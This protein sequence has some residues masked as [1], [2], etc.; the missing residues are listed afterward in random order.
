MDELPEV[1]ALVQAGWVPFD[2]SGYQLAVLAAWPA[3]LRGW[4]EDRRPKVVVRVWLDGRREVVPAYGRGD[5]YEEMCETA[6]ECG[7]PAPPR[8]RVWLLRSPWS[9]LGVNVVVRMIWL[10]LEHDDSGP[11][12]VLAVAR[13]ILAMTADEVWQV[14]P[15][16]MRAAAEAWSAAGRS[17]EDVA[18]LV[19]RGLHPVHLERLR[20]AGPVDE[21]LTDAQAAA[22]V[23]AVASSEVD[24][25]AAVERVAQWRELGV[26]APDGDCRP[27]PLSDIAPSEARTWIQAGF[28]VDELE[29]WLG[30]DLADAEK[31]RS[32]GFEARVARD[33]LL[34]DPQLTPVEARAFDAVGVTVEARTRWV[35][36]GFSA[37]EARAWTD[38]DVVPAEARVWRSVGIGP[39]GAD[40]QLAS[41][42]DASP[43]LPSGVAVGWGAMGTGR[44]DVNYGV[45]DPPG[46]RGSAAATGW[47]GIPDHLPDH[48]RDDLPD[49]G[50]V[51]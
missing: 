35:A 50:P 34:A 24:T 14:V 2:G 32:A 5:P 10:R 41:G 19:C 33:L 36:T 18:E 38:L 22:W 44:D 37:A 42:R 47:D 46:T 45:V 31:W 4:V 27:W 21:A 11:A 28:G 23:G 16:E 15:P 43:P 25:A 1:A 9:G 30:V 17:G 8:G 13:E 12:A 7:L 49:D 26:P 3:E 40:A 51:G 48:P 6:A 39:E 29:T 20:A